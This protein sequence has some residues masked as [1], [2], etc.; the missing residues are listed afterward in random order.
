MHIELAY[1]FTTNRITIKY[2]FAGDSFEITDDEVINNIVSKCNK[3]SYN[4]I[5]NPTNSLCGM[6]IDFHNGLIIGIYEDTY[7]GYVGH[8]I[9]DISTGN[10]FDTSLP[11]KLVNLISSL[12]NEYKSNGT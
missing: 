1:D 8:S 7:Y 3:A 5:I 6:W 4:T 2:S 11:K 10:S 12:I 9:E